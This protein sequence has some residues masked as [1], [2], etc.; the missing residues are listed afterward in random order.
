MADVSREE[1]EREVTRA[2]QHLAERVATLEHAIREKM[3]VPAR[4]RVV[5]ARARGEVRA[6]RQRYAIM[7]GVVLALGIAIVMLRRRWT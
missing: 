2:K 6:H 1:L 3:A 4:A 7:A 5:L